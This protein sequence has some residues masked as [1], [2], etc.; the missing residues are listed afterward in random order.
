MF[1]QGGFT[2]YASVVVPV[3]QEQLGHVGQGFITRRVTDYLNLAG[4]VA[5]LPLAWDIAAGRDPSPTRRRIRWSAWLGMVITLVGLALL[6]RYLESQLDP[7]AYEILDRR[8]FRRGH[9]WYL[10]IC[11][12]QWSF[13]LIYM[14]FMLRAWG[15][16]DHQETAIHKD[17]K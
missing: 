4:A 12:V 17:S 11:T 14:G 7:E 6:H 13:C 3:G 9:R 10:W 15:V 16:V 1:W 2:F 8:I 5:L